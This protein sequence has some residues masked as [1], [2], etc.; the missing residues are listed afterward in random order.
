MNIPSNNSASNEED[1]QNT[2]AEGNGFADIF[3]STSWYSYGFLVA[4]ISSLDDE[5]EYD[6][7]VVYDY[8]S[9]EIKNKEENS[10]EIE[11]PICLNHINNNENKIHKT[12]CGHEFCEDCLKRSLKRNSELSRT[13]SCPMCRTCI[14]SIDEISV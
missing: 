7:N 1:R 4:T 5:Y 6:E 8:F 9:I 13:P 3:L 2:A 11:C 10:R 12:N 14:Y